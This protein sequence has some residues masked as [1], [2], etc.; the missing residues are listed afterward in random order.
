[1]VKIDGEFSQ[2]IATDIDNQALVAAM[3]AIARQFDMLVVAEAVETAEE[4]AALRRL[5]VDCMQ[6]YAFGLPTV[7]PAFLATMPAKARGS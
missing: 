2:G 3:I 1:V 5:G 4:A 7:Q 6:G